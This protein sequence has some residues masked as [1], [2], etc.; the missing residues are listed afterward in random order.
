MD[1]RQP[2]R[3]KTGLAGSTER[4]LPPARAPKTYGRDGEKAGRGLSINGSGGFDSR[5]SAEARIG[6]TAT[7]VGG[8]G[9]VLTR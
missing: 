3:V 4:T 9:G 6:V 7:E 8:K 1:Q 5:T 2:H